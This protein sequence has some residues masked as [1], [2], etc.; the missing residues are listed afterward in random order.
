[1]LAR[2]GARTRPE[3]HSTPCLTPHLTRC[4]AML[5]WDVCADADVCTELI[6]QIGGSGV[7][8]APTDAAADGAVPIQ[9]APAAAVA[10]DAESSERV[11]LR[12]ELC[13]ETRCEGHFEG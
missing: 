11:M 7:A 6:Q 4:I 13:H 8:H 9:D 12:D 10:A 1:M 2:D 5:R 3:P